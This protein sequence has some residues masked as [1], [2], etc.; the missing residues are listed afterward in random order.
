M[1]LTF[2]I[3]TYTNTYLLFFWIWYCSV[4]YWHSPFNSKDTR[5]FFY[6]FH[7]LSTC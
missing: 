7:R 4:C 1:E 3:L 6:V 5:S 2:T